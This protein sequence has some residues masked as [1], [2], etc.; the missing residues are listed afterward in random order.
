MGIRGGVQIL[1][2][3]ALGGKAQPVRTLSHRGRIDQLLYHP[4]SRA[5][6]ARSHNNRV[7][8]WDGKS[9][10]PVRTVM[11]DMFI[12]GSILP[13][14][15][16]DVPDIKNPSCVILSNSSEGLR[17]WMPLRE[18]GDRMTVREIY[19]RYVRGS[20]LGHISA[21][22]V[23]GG[24]LVLG[25]DQGELLRISDPKSMFEHDGYDDVVLPSIQSNNLT[26]GRFR[27]H[28][29]AI[30]SIGVS[31]DTGRCL[32]AGV[33]GKVRVWNLRDLPVDMLRRFK[34]KP[35]WEIPGRVATLSANGRF[36]AVAN[37]N[38][39]GVY[40]AESGISIAWNPTG[41]K[42]GRIVRLLFSPDGASLLDPTD[43]VY[44]SMKIERDYTWGNYKGQLVI[45]TPT[46][47]LTA[48]KDVAARGKDHTGLPENPEGL[49]GRFK[50]LDP[51]MHGYK[52][53][54]RKDEKKLLSR[55]GKRRL[56]GILEVSPDEPSL[57]KSLDLEELVAK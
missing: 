13:T 24:V 30:T 32:T 44:G 51:D 45:A 39:L 56:W 12:L 29:G 47:W 53:L 41:A 27:T 20:R 34:P 55:T 19:L 9:L 14:F 37:R 36:L 50:E 52:F 43:P 18:T 33:D 11:E 16:A 26:L 10:R 57:D 21:A 17:L 48:L 40:H 4:E 35:E 8:V 5:L 2:P 25:N 38:G 3:A 46:R 1:L 42:F 15:T 49:K 23:Y 7:H 6:I 31:Q 54:T 28:E 22:T